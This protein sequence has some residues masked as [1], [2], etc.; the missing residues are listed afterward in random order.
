M[1]EKEGVKSNSHDSNLTR[2]LPDKI[3]Y[4]ASTNCI[5]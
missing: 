4:V 2:S 5:I 3:S 1:E